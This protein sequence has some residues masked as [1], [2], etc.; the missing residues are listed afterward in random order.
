MARAN[1]PLPD[2][3]SAASVSGQFTVTEMP[4]LAPLAGLPEV[5]ANDDLVHLDP[6]TLAV[7]ADRFR[8]S[9][10]RK[11][12]V[13]PASTWSG[14]IYLSLHP[15][16]ALDE[17]V[18]IYISRFGNGWDYH[19][20]LPDIVQR[21][22]LAR[23][24][25]GVLLLEYANRNATDRAAEVPVWL[26][27]GM[28]QELLT[29]SLQDPIVSVP[30]QM[31]DNIELQRDNSTS[32]GTDHLAN[33][34][35]IFRNYSVVSFNELSWPT[36][37]EISGE[38]GGAYRASAQLFLDELLALPNGGGKLRAMLQ[39]LPQHYNWQT[40]FWSAYHDDFVSALQVEKWWALHSVIFV[41]H[42]PGPQ[43]T[44]ATSRERLDEILS[45]PVQFRT[46][47]NDVPTT[48]EVSIQSV[49]QNFDSERQIE[50][51]QGKLHDLEVAQFRIAPSLA[52]L[53]A[54]YRDT[55]AAYLGESWVTRKDTVVNRRSASP[56]S[57][58]E[59]IR[60]LNVLDA[61]RRA[62][63]IA[64]RE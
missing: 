6:A 19:I 35:Q 40:A 16:Q 26:A 25:T 42:S 33:A 3:A 43:W 57:A 32:R 23:A 17:P 49:I 18:K 30:G 59:T 21:E 62:F 45:V 14:K 41:S 46:T 58:R 38:D 1:Y 60:R 11:I 52:V 12:G 13:D 5:A 50:I 31:V 37:L 44:I 4:G 55:L 54:G 8:E 27:E 56:A 47:T 2:M 15:A 28:S 36:A 7:S 34:R 39:A 20:V 51:L 64:A 63:S 24:L 29:D 9:F 22:R 10:L 48:T 53:T 61:Q